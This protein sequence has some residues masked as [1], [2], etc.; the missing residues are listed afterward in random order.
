V[1]YAETMSEMKLEM[2]RPSG[3]TVTAN[4]IVAAVINNGPRG[5]RRIS[6]KARP[7]TTIA[8]A[9][10]K[11]T[12]AATPGRMLLMRVEKYESGISTSSRTAAPNGPEFANCSGGS[13]SLSNPTND[14]ATPSPS[15]Q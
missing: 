12:S 5:A 3:R 2:T 15:R 10:A 7:T 6:G 11:T 9:A 8:V 1:A 13:P 4:T 14:T